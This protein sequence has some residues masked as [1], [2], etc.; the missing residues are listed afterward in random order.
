MPLAQ[1]LPLSEMIYSA[2]LRRHSS[3][4]A[5]RHTCIALN[6]QVPGR[7]TAWS[8]SKHLAAHWL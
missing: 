6:R 8:S 3:V 4:V 1:A 5:I 2:R 7:H